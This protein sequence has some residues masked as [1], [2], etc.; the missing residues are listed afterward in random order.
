VRLLLDECVD[1]R[2]ASDIVG[3][4]VTTS[5]D[6]GWAGLTNGELLSQAQLH[7]DAL[8]TVDRRL[9]FQQNLAR[10]SIAVVVL[11]ARSNR[12]ADLRLLVPELLVALGVAKPGEATWVGAE[13]RT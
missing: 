2:L 11:R 8:I 4:E 13:Q 10:F 5:P 6:A 7:F 1:R 12:L 3:H 9:P